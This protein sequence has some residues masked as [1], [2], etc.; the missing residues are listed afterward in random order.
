MKNNNIKISTA[1]TCK[2]VE[3]LNGIA[4]MEEIPRALIIRKA[5]AQYLEMKSKENKR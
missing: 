1:I 3:D 5:I 2:Q 4:K